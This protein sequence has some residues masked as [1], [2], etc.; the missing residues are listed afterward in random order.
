MAEIQRPQL[1]QL[2]VGLELA[3][4]RH[5]MLEQRVGRRKARVGVVHRRGGNAE[6]ATRG[7]RFF[8]VLLEQMTRLVLQELAW[9]DRRDLHV[10]AVRPL[11]ERV[12]RHLLFVVPRG[13]FPCHDAV[14]PAMPRARDEF[15]GPPSLGERPALVIARIRNR[16]EPA[17]V[18]EHGDT[19]PLDFRGERDAREELVFRAQSVPLGHGTLQ[20]KEWL[21]AIFV[22]PCPHPAPASASSSSRS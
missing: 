20:E 7:T 8:G 16:R 14:F 2:R 19:I 6:D 1:D 3:G 11:V 5:R 12:D 21:N 15:A 18:E 4:A 9:R 10:D 13:P 17:V 22:A